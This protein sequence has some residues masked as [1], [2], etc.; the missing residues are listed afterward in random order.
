MPLDAL[1]DDWDLETPEIPERSR[2]YCL[3]PVGIGTCQVESLTG[4]VARLA[5]AHDLSVGNLVGRKPFSNARSGLYKRTTFFRLARPKSHVFHAAAH[6]IN[7][8]CQ[9]VGKWIRVFE[10]ATHRQDLCG[11]TLVPLMKVVSDMLLLRKGRAW[12]PSCYHEDRKSGLVYERL[13]WAIEVAAICPFHLRQL[14]VVCPFCNRQQATL[15]VN[16]RPGYCSACRNW[17][18]EPISSTIAKQGDRVRFDF[19]NEVYKAASVGEI[20]AVTSVAESIYAARFRANLRIC[21]KRLAAG[22]TAAFAR[23]TRISESAISCWL[24]A[25]MLPRLDTVLRMCSYLGISA[26]SMLVNDCLERPVDW[27]A[28]TTGFPPD[29]LQIKTFRSSG[30]VRRLLVAALRQDDCPSLREL[31]IRLGYKRA[32]SLYQADRELCHQ[33]TAKY[34]RCHRTHW[35]REPGARRICDEETLRRL[36]EESLA[37]ETPT[38]V[39]RIAAIAGYANGGYIHRKFPDL[40]QAIARRIEEQK[41]RRW[42]NMRL[43]LESICAGGLPPSLHAI[44]TQLGFRN[45]STLREKFPEECDELL[46]RRRRHK[47]KAIETLR[48]KLQP[49]L[50][51]EPAPSLSAVCRKL[52]I[53]HS[54]LYERCPE[55]C[56]AISARHAN[57]QN[58]R[59]R[60]RRQALDEEVRRIAGDLRAHGQNPTQTRIRLLLST[61]SLKE[62]RALQRSVKRARRFLGLK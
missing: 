14:E 61:D 39:R 33:I 13:L 36:L 55:L 18:G 15:G 25:T 7:G 54:T 30:Q 56:R 57:W 29:K 49:I 62:W 11:L 51:E 6:D 58:D 3:K 52:Q 59:T 24:D 46:A 23:R 45:S 5:E 44:S 34:Q 10:A 19:R 37:Q 35:W 1:Y 16:S 41:A 21:I 32:E 43:A 38:S 53:S 22:N 8:M 47:E 27:K 4:Y 2:L 12:C 20:L 48:R 9:K 50:S 26:A 31:T 40:C 17:L 42:D 60:K 28:V